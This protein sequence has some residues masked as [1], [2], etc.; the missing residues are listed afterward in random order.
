[1]AAREPQRGSPGPLSGPIAQPAKEMVTGE[2]PFLIACLP[3]PL[4][5]ALSVLRTGPAMRRRDGESDES[6]SAET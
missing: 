1:V 4:I 3:E 2:P 5:I 6:V